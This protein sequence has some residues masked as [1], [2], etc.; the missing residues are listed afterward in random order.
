MSHSFYCSFE[1]GEPYTVFTRF[2][3]PTALIINNSRVFT[4][5]YIDTP[6]VIENHTVFCCLS[7]GSLPIF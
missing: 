3:K 4:Y 2:G 7:Q 5:N 6:Q 1:Q